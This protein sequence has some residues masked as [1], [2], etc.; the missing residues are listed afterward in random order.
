[1]LAISFAA[2]ATPKFPR[3]RAQGCSPKLP[4]VLHLPSSLRFVFAAPPLLFTLRRVS[5]SLHLA[6][7]LPFSSPCAASLHPVP[8]HLQFDPPHPLTILPQSIPSS[9]PSDRRPQATCSVRLYRK[10][11][12]EPADGMLRSAFRCGLVTLLLL[13]LNFQAL[14]LNWIDSKVIFILLP[15]F[16]R[17]TVVPIH[18]RD[19][20]CSTA[21]FD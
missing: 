20:D 18:C 5:P 12:G 9:K 7:C 3:R 11:H 1:V 21:K 4:T 14:A 19:L 13:V 15:F 16:N 6:P 8:P 17:S 10:C 2:L